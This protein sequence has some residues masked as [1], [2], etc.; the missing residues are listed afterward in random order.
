QFHEQVLTGGGNELLA[1]LWPPIQVILQWVGNLRAAGDHIG[2][3]DEATSAYAGA[4]ARIAGGDAEGSMV[5]MA[6]LID[7]NLN[8]AL[9]VVQRARAAGARPD[10]SVETA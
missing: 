1:A 6:H 3:D 10:R 7:M 9:E 5:A 2:T 4:F 8:E